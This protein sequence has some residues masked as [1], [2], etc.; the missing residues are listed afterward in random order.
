MLETVD[1][2]RKQSTANISRTFKGFSFEICF[3]AF[4]RGCRSYQSFVQLQKLQVIAHCVWDEARQSRT[5]RIQG[6]QVGSFETWKILRSTLLYFFFGQPLLR[7]RKFESFLVNF[8]RNMHEQHLE[9]LWHAKAWKR[10]IREFA[11]ERETKQRIDQNNF[12]NKVRFLRWKD[13]TICEAPRRKFTNYV[14]NQLER[15]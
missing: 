1:G 4:S 8:R 7:L 3:S 10:S 12:E 14:V 13:G 5:F 2:P 11:Y 15:A 6:Y 9:T